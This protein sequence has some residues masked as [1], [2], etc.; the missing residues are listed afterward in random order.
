MRRTAILLLVLAGLA[1]CGGGSDDQ[2]SSSTSAKPLYVT[3]Q[4]MDGTIR[5]TGACTQI[6]VPLTSKSAASDLSGELGTI[7]RPDGTRQVTLDG[8]PLY[9]FAEDGSDGKA[10]GDG[11]KDS[12]GGV[13]FTWHAKS[14]D[15][16][17]G[18]GGSSYGY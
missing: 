10:T 18:G 7:K 13:Q 4:E 6:W 1:G 11:V 16:T 2:G 17:A 3:D 5:C 9:H 8:R 12:F 15:S 14:G